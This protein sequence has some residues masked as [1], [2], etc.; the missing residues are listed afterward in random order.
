MTIIKS[1]IKDYQH[2]WYLKN[3][4]KLQIRNRLYR[5]S[6]MEE[7]RQYNKKYYHKNKEILAIKKKPYRKNHEEQ[8]RTYSKKNQRRIR[9]QVIFHYSKGLMCCSCCGESILQMLAIDH[10]NGGGNKHRKEIKKYGGDQFYRWLLKN[11]FPS[12]YKVLCANCNW[13]KYVNNNICPHKEKNNDWESE[14]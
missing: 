6:H 5:K 10:P 12:G 8:I 13:G 2:K 14:L 11:N 9:Q 7:F 4:W 1:S 3:K